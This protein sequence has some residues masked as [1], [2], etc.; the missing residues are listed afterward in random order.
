MTSRALFVGL[1]SVVIAVVLQT[2][3]FV[4]DSLRFFDA[5]P[6][7]VLVAVVASAL[8]LDAEP[9]IFLG[10]TG[11]LLTD[12]LGGSPLGLWSLVMTVVAYVAVRL[13]GMVVDRWLLV[14]P[15]VLLLAIGAG[16]LF[17]GDATL[18]GEQPFKDPG[19]FRII[20]LTAVYS[21][22]T[23][24]VIVPLMG[25]AMQPRRTRRNAAL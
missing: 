18:F 19:V 14:V 10:F 23:A 1:T 22:A 5:T 20:T 3:L 7:L 8:A 9:A 15:G 12:L 16:V 17:V 2:T 4:N 25:W 24:L 6:N 11:G 13:R 21:S